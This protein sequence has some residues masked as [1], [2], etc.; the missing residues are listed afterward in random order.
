[1]TERQN[2]RYVQFQTPTGRGYACVSFT[3][4]RHGDVIKYVAGIAFCSPLDAFSKSLAR[5]SAERRRVGSDRV[6]SKNKRVVSQVSSPNPTTTFITN[7]EFDAIF[8]DVISAVSSKNE[9]PKW[10]LDAV[11]VS[12]IHFGL[13]DF[14]PPS[15]ENQA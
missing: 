9:V 15:V 5:S 1:M 7:K 12:D 11:D 6:K 8:R 10:A 4:E 2:Y 13:T 14:V 3:W